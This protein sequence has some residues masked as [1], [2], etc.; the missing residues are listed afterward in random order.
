MKHWPGGL[1]VRGGSI[2]A[3]PHTTLTTDTTD[4]ETD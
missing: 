2:G 3:R 4:T 1:I